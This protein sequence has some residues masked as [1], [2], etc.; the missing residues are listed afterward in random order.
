M[1]DRPWGQTLGTVGM[2]KLDAQ[3]TLTTDDG[4]MYA[5]A[6]VGGAIVASASPLPNDS[7]TR[8]ALT[9]HYVSP[10]QVNEITRRLG[11][12]KD[13]DEV[14]VVAEAGKLN[15]EH[16]ATLR[17]RLLIQRAAR[18]FAID[19][20]TFAIEDEISLRLSPGFAVPLG[21]VIFHGVRMNLSE[22][23]LVED[24]RELGTSFHLKLSTTDM[25]LAGYEFEGD[26]RSVIAALRKGTSLAELELASHRDIEPRTLQA[27]IYA[28]VCG[29]HC[30]AAGGQ[31]VDRT[32]PPA[33]RTS[34]GLVNPS[35][36]V[37]PGPS[38]TKPPP[39]RITVDQPLVTRT[40]TT[41]APTNMPRTLT[42]VS[43]VL[44]EL[45]RTTTPGTPGPRSP[46][47]PPETRPSRAPTPPLPRATTPPPM[48]SQTTPPLT[49][50][51]MTKPGIP[52]RT[53]AGTVP[54]RTMT[55]LPGQPPLR[56][57]TMPPPRHQS[58]SV[59]PLDEFIKET[60][61]S[62]GFTTLADGTPGTGPHPLVDEFKRETTT[63]RGMPTLPPIASRTITAPRT[64]TERDR[65][66]KE[67]EA[68]ITQ[69]LAKLE[70]GCDYFAI[71]G[72]PFEAPLDAVRN[73]YVETSRRLHPESLLSVGIL[74]EERT[75]QRVLAQVNAAFT[76]L[77]DAQ[78][79]RDYINAVR[80]GE[81][82]PLAPRARTGDLDKKELA[83]EAF[84]AGEGALK[85]DDIPRAVEELGRA[86]TL[87]PANHEYAAMF[88]WAQ[89]CAAA[90]KPQVYPETRKALER[91]IHRGE[92]PVTARFYLGRVER[93]VGHDREAFNHF[94]EV[95][96]D[97]PN[98]REAASEL[99][100]LEQKIARG[101]KPKR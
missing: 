71:L 59:S 34:T 67:I 1:L 20:A 24:M 5:I 62:R 96:L 100:I 33:P 49:G 50:R 15:T 32:V 88:A 11:T 25:D 72:L 90:D 53:S 77:T 45:A 89:F 94:Q 51:A 44:P 52:G 38:P 92:K 6:F 42:P 7:V 83:A 10:M 86:V 27:M 73:N 87:V 37:T 60:T 9:S 81:P 43:E 98:N 82:T 75:A 70:Q 93:M 56:S 97:E 99:R 61:T 57:A 58:P 31:P 64:I 21:A 23:R 22:Q 47:L 91:A 76:T 65:A 19:R 29:G 79:R 101:T 66:R 14:E 28:L 4:K 80:R 48:R 3:I 85:R 63:S 2:R 18:T 41:A 69:R 36:L 39:T 78:K 8:V 54:P 40:R 35:G 95:L 13:R 12:E 16:T 55:P 17:R 26:T 74:D 84:E 30:D 46:T 68:L